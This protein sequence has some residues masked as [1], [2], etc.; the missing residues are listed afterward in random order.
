MAACSSAL[1]SVF[2]LVLSLLLLL[3][4]LV[5]LIAPRDSSAPDFT[6]ISISSHESGSLDSSV[7][8]RSDSAPEL[9]QNEETAARLRA[10][11]DENEL[12]S[13]QVNTAESRTHRITHT[14]THTNRHVK[15]DRLK[16][17]VD[18]FVQATDRKLVLQPWTSGQTSFSDE[19]QRLIQFITTPEV[20]CSRWQGSVESGS[21]YAGG[22]SEA[23]CFNYWAPGRPCVAYSFSL[24]GKD[25]MILES[26]LSMRCEVH[27]FD[28]STR[29]KH[30]SG[31]GYGSVQHHQAWLDWRRPH[32][33]P[34]R[35]V[36]GTIP[37]RLVDIMDSL[38]HS[39]VHVL[40]ADLE[41]A[42]WRVLE[43]WVQDGTLRRIS[44]L[45]LTVHLQ[46]AGFEVGG[47]EA[48]VVRFWYSVL[49]A[50]HSSGF[51]L[52][53]SVPGPGHTVLRQQL[54]NT[55]SSYKLTWVRMGEQFK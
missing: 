38:G 41:S 22:S 54:P 1:P 31:S 18:L 5:S 20:N 30:G 37:R 51:R 16:R 24:D 7:D 34:H 27:R 17:P 49:R 55:H 9:W 43:S 8:A 13:R 47:T 23:L 21:A 19:V 44:Q 11:A 29:R 10:Y 2:T 25:A 4:L 33:R 39:M 32:T 53:Y 26:T 15:F 36:L 6:V 45:I 40:W 35:G 14:H 3:Q 12:N 42:E 28:P 52:T 48:E 50:L 46:W